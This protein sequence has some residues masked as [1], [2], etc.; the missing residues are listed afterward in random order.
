MARLAGIDLPR[1]KRIE[2]AL[3]YIYGVGPANAAKM[4]ALTGINPD[5]RAKD[6]TEDDEKKLRDAIDTLQIR[7]E[8]DLRREVQGNINA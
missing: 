2:I 8:G 3:Q 4:L 7:V 5:T 6:L 1:E